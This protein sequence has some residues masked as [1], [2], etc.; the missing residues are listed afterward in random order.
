MLEENCFLILKDFQNEGKN[1]QKR[2][3]GINTF[4]K[5]KKPPWV[6]SILF[7]SNLFAACIPQAS[8]PFRSVEFSEFHCVFA[9]TS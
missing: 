1:I 4:Y 7:Y 9:Q 3:V 5:G 2:A 8:I 6:E